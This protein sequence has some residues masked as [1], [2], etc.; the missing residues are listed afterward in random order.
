MER[1]KGFHH[2]RY[3]KKFK[4]LFKKWENMSDFSVRM[5]IMSLGLLPV[6]GAELFAPRPRNG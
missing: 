4:K 1:I 3:V 2:L 5:K 6:R